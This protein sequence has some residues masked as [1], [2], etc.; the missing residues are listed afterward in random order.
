MMKRVLAFTGAVMMG[1]GG[2]LGV[3]AADPGGKVTVCKQVSTPGNSRRQSGDG[4]ITVSQNAIN[5][6]HFTDSQGSTAVFANGTCTADPAT[7]TATATSV[8]GAVVAHAA[9]TG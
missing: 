7:A 4:T 6:P 1:V 3:A 5:N 9:L 2:L 8:A